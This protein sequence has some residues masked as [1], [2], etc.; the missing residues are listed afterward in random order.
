MPRPPDSYVVLLPVKPPGRGKS[1]LRGVPREALARAFALD[2]AIACLA[3]PPIN[4][5]LVVT[6]DARFAS[7]LSALGCQSIPDGV[8][9]DLNATLGLAALEAARRWPEL[10]PVA[11]C[12]DLPC[13]TPVD[14]ELA[15]AQEPGRPRFVADTAGDGTTM[16]TAPLAQFAP[17]FGFRSASSHVEAGAWPVAGELARLRHDV[18]DVDDL[19]HAIELGLGE[20]SAAAVAALPRTQ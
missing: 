7:A 10:V 11:M 4:K 8:S 6:D 14:L 17:R 2:T 9:Q 1:R 3:S 18:D 20:H 5:V 15:L 13:L 16:Y 19:E 12:A